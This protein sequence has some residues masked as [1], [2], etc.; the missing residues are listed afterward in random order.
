MFTF[1]THCTVEEEV[2]EQLQ[3]LKEKESVDE[4]NLTNL[5]PRKPDWSVAELEV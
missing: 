4:V 1:S 3:V 2:T 5:A